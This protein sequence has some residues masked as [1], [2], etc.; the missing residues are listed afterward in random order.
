MC[1]LVV[2]ITTAYGFVSEK[3]DYDDEVERDAEEEDRGQ[4]DGGEGVKALVQNRHVA[5]AVGPSRGFVHLENF[6]RGEDFSHS[7]SF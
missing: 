3:E 6:A 1:V 5:I 4:V 2:I 7:S